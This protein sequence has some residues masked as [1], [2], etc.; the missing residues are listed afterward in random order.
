MLLLGDLRQEEGMSH[1]SDKNNQDR[2]DLY[3]QGLSDYEIGKIMNIAQS[4]IYYWRKRKGLF[5]NYK[6]TPKHIL[7]KRRTKINNEYLKN[8][9]IDMNMVTERRSYVFNHLRKIPDSKR[10]ITSDKRLFGRRM[11]YFYDNNRKENFIKFLEDE[12][13][14]HIR[15]EYR[16]E[17][18]QQRTI[19]RLFSTILNEHDLRVYDG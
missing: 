16:N 15:K 17:K 3:N 12:F 14:K 8:G 19:R 18:Q 2:L 1:L 9:Y 11:Y 6:T 13:H 7:K 5:A 10:F 4:A